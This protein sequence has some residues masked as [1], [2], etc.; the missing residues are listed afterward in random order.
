MQRHDPQGCRAMSAGR[1]D[2]RL[3]AGSL[4]SILSCHTLAIRIEQE[5]LSP[6]DCATTA[7]M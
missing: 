4:V 3:G 7:S 6:G 1:L 2:A 5:L